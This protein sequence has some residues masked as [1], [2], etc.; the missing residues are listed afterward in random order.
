M[1][2]SI[3]CAAVGVCLCDVRLCCVL[4]CLPP[5]VIYMCG[6]M[7]VCALSKLSLSQVQV[8]LWAA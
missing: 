4:P 5:A 6:A 2:R 3:L 7:Y 1:T 8:L